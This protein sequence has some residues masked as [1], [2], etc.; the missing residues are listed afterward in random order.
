MSQRVI[1]PAVLLVALAVSAIYIVSLRGE[2]AAVK[3]ATTESTAAAPPRPPAMQGTSLLPRTLT[4]EQRQVMLDVLRAEPASERMV[5]FQVD[6]NDSEASAYQQALE[7]V[8]REAGW[9][10]E[11][12]GAAGMTFKPGI[13]FLVGDEEWPPYASTAHDA[14]QR[15]GIE[16]NAAR[17]YRAYYQQQK[18]EK[19]G[20]R[21]PELDAGQAYVVLIGRNA[22]SGG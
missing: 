14:F 4:D 9:K 3:R 2:L 16:V 20:W 21:G 10:I 11:R 17:G 18:A 5:W 15:A 1:V 13:F 8:F 7:A 19:P 6:A 12:K 22:V